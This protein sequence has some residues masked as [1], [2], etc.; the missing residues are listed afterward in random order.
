MPGTEGSCLTFVS[1]DGI[2]EELDQKVYEKNFQS[3]EAR[4]L[5]LK[6]FEQDSRPL[7]RD[8]HGHRAVFWRQDNVT[9]LTRGAVKLCQAEMC[10]PSM[11]PFAII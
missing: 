2:Y 4:K 3:L 8:A 10:C 6:A 1:Q 5:P 9:K 7:K 11:N